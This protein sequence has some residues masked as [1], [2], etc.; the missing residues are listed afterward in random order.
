MDFLSIHEKRRI[1]PVDQGGRRRRISICLR[2][3]ALKGGITMVCHQFFLPTI[4]I[5]SGNGRK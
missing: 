3:L 2:N 1:N 4:D 5:W